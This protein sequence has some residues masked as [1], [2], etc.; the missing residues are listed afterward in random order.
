MI[1]KDLGNKY[2]EEIQFKRQNKYANL[3][4]WQKQKD[5]AFMLYAVSLI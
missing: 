2:G 3:A 4:L 5:I 1:I